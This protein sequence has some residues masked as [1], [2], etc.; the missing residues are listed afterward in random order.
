MVREAPWQWTNLDERPAPRLAGGIVADS[1]GL[2]WAA[3]A[4]ADPA[5]KPGMDP[6]DG[7]ERYFDTLVL[8]IDPVKRAVVGQIRINPICQAMEGGVISCVDEMAQTVGIVALELEP[9]A[10]SGP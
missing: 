6:R 3:F 1:T 9:G 4:V 5:W 10:P 8:V 7:V 2:L